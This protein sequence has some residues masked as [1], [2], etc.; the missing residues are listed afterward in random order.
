M[1][2]PFAS[3]ANEA[4]FLL[5]MILGTASFTVPG[6]GTNH[7]DI[8]PRHAGVLVGIT[9]TVGTIPGVA[10]VAFT[11]WLIDTTG[12]YNSVFLMIAGINLTGAAIWL[13]YSTG[14]RLVD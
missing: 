11:G 7:L 1:M 5:C 8:A 3:T 10:G 14:E 12:N 13:I 4:V 9:N 2:M 6:Y